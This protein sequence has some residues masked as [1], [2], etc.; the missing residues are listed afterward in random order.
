MKLEELVLHGANAHYVTLCY[1]GRTYG[2]ISTVLFAGMLS[3]KCVKMTILANAPEMFMRASYSANFARSLCVPVDA[4][5]YQRIAGLPGTCPR[6]AGGT[7]ENYK[8]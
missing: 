6:S 8:N 1:F 2:K 4:M 5:M 3:K 7:L